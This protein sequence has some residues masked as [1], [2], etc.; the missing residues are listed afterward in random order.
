M[1]E[2]G[3]TR[4]L[5]I[6]GSPRIGGNTDI[7]TDMVLDGARKDGAQ[8]EKLLLSR[9]EISPCQACYACRESGE[10][11]LKDDFAAVLDKMKASQVWVLGTPVYWWGP[12]AQLKAFVDRWFSKAA[13]PGQSEVFKGRKIILVVPMGD[14]NE[15]TARHVVGMFE[16]ALA[17]IG[18]ELH[19]T[20]LAPGAYD[21]GDVKGMEDVLEKARQAGRSAITP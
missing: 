13:E 1:A 3:P 19:A 2:S 15:G 16:D 18:A 21:K 11:V 4:V 17:Y 8:V 20:V 14:T 6:M 7:L 10:C 9:L 5:G 12:S